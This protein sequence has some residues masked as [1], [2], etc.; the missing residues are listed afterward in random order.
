VSDDE[1]QND[2]AVLDATRKLYKAHQ[3]L[4]DANKNPQPAG[5][6]ETYEYYR[7][8]A[9]AHNNLIRNLNEM[10]EMCEKYGVTRL[11]YR[12][13][14]PSNPYRTAP[15]DPQLNARQEE[16]R[17]I[18]E[19]YFGAA[20]GDFS[21]RQTFDHYGRGGTVSEADGGTVNLFDDLYLAPEESEDKEWV[22]MRKL[23]HLQKKRGE[24]AKKAA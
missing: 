7:T 3:D 20:F 15:I 12:N 22:R 18:V 16:D 5:T 17:A 24:A 6:L 4:T 10:N 19:Q 14:M 11:T 2:A 13:F 1:R 8:R 23:E 21:L 9:T